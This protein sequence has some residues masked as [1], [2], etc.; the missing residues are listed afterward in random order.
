MQNH[1][2]TTTSN[3]DLDVLSFGSWP[4][5]D[6][7]KIDG[8]PRAIVD[9]RTDLK[10]DLPW[11]IHGYWN[12]V[13]LPESIAVC[14]D[15]AKEYVSN[16]DGAGKSV[17]PSVN[18]EN[19]RFL[20]D[21]DGYSKGDII[22]S[23]QAQIM[24][25]VMFALENKSRYQVPEVQLQMLMTFELYCRKLHAQHS[26]DVRPFARDELSKPSA[27]WEDWI[28]AE[29][30]RRA[31]SFWF[32][33]S[34]VVDVRFGATCASITNYRNLP[35]PSPGSLWTA[36][37]REEFEAARELHRPADMSLLRTYGDLI[38]ARLSSRDPKTQRQLN[39]WHANCDKL[40]LLLTLATTTV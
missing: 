22:A 36:R 35:L 12:E 13:T 28:Y 33:L 31:A 19:R 11:F 8:S 26:W 39:K 14:I 38:D 6:P 2:T 21:L 10:K 27:T 5:L 23:M 1:E 34:R 40:G 16:G 29:T 15:I 18:E 3:H 20:R 25:M 4:S 37:T 7:S 30:R 24:Y 9:F 32:L 17:W